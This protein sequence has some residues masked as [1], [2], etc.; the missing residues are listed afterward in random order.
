MGRRADAVP[1]DVVAWNL[2]P[3]QFKTT[4]EEDEGGDPEI[5]RMQKV[6]TTC[7][8][9]IFEKHDNTSVEPYRAEIIRAV[10]E[11]KCSIRTFF[12]SAMLGYVHRRRDAVGHLE[13]IGGKFTPKFLSTKSAI[14]LAKNYADLCR[15]QFGTFTTDDL[16][17]TGDSGAATPEMVQ[18]MER[19]ELVAAKFIV[20]AKAG[21]K[22][23]Y[24]TVEQD[25]YRRLELHLHPHWLAIEPSYKELVL[26][27]YLARKEGTT[28]QKQHRYNVIQALRHFKRYPTA[29]HAA[30]IARTHA[31]PK[32]VTKVLAHYRYDANDFMITNTTQ[33]DS[34]EF[35]KE[36]G[37]AIQQLYAYRLYHGNRYP[38]SIEAHG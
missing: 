31:M 3:E 2:V 29:G 24:N 5:A 16:L 15:A 32:V 19:S 18:A 12:L 30:F 4:I 21:D 28:H 8:L 17:R 9:H 6:Y 7:Y 36:L 37:R 1:I 25:L 35:W 20:A 33:T 14:T 13:G 22:T 38:G 27:S 34:F 10:R 26:D 23:I 11:L